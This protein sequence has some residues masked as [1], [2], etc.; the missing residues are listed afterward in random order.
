MKLT[1]R[2][3]CILIALAGA[4]LRLALSARNEVF[5]DRLFV[6]DDAYYTLSIARS[7][8]RGFGPSADGVHLTNGFQPLLA[9]LLVP[10]PSLRVA[11]AIGAITD[12]L[13]A[14]FLGRLAQNSSGSETAAVVATTIWALAPSA[15]ATALNGLE[16][17]LAIACVTGAL[18]LW[19]TDRSRLGTGAA[20]GLCLLARVDTIFIVAAVGI[21]TLR[22]DGLQR[23][24]PLVAGAVLVVAPWWGYSL[25][26]F[27]TFIPESG[28]AVR[29]QAMLYRASGM[30]VRDQVAWAAAA[31]IPFADL[32]WLRELLG[33]TASALGLAAGVLA[34]GAGGWFFRRTNDAVLRAFLAYALG[35]FVFYSLYLPA[36]WFF[37]RYLVP[38][39]ALV[40]LIVALHV[41]RRV[42]AAAGVVA[43]VGLLRFLGSPAETV[44][45][46]HHGAKGYREP[47]RQMLALAPNGAVIGSFQSGALGWFADGTGRQVVNLDGV[48]DGESARALR[49]GKLADHAITRHITHLADWDVNVKRFQER[50]GRRPP[51]YLRRVGEAEPQGR[52]E[53]FVLYEI[54]WPE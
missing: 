40:A 54:E 17:S 29:E 22:R 19:Q 25:A 50:S 30:V 20:L 32:A 3:A 34:V 38:I 24:W 18:L 15:V 11:L 51:V 6:P 46:G 5:V 36:T 16:T 44:D 23:T 43:L 41:R 33:S 2:H 53:R 45:Q 28:A 37:R 7:I 21:L 42:W 31:V 48:V 26:R 4:V 8:G 10:F 47:A 13:T 12:G 39:H 9:F 49:D 52:D 27:G 14:W 35:L 1:P